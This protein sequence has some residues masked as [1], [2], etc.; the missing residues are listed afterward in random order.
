MLSL[1]G[2]HLPNI[3]GMMPLKAMKFSINISKQPTRMGY[4]RWARLSGV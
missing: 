4:S 3:S 2:I 1:K